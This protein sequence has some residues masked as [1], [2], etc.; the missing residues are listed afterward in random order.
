[1]IRAL[2]IAL[3]LVGCSGGLQSMAWEVDCRGSTVAELDQRY[4]EE[5]AALE[6]SGSCEVGD[7]LPGG[8][9][10][11]SV[12]ECAEYHRIWR[13]YWAARRELGECHA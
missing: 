5:V 8:T 4:T 11:A 9:Y 7:P 3:L 13:R 6:D 2:L 12:A 1:M 10:V